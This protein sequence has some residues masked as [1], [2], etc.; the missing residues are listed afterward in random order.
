MAAIALDPA[1][2]RVSVEEFLKMDFG[3]ARAELE[4]GLIYMM[5]ASPT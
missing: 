5:S 1:Y 2:R 3:G 4:D